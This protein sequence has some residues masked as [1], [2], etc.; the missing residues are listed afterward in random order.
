[1]KTK[2]LL[3][4]LAIGSSGAAANPPGKLVQEREK[5]LRQLVDEAERKVQL[6]SEATALEEV[7]AAKTA[8]LSF[9]RDRA[10]ERLEKAVHQQALVDELHRYRKA[11]EEAAAA[12]KLPKRAALKALDAELQAR[13]TL[14]ELSNGGSK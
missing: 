5:V 12:G 2:I 8:L 3:L 7:C 1:M 4:C 11:C 13:M 10:K 6:G 9:L 14:E